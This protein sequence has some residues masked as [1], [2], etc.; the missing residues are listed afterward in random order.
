MT[1]LGE[2]N[3][4]TEPNA[5][6][7]KYSWLI[8]SDMPESTIHIHAT[9]KDSLGNSST[10]CMADRYIKVVADEEEKGQPYCGNGIIDPGET[11]DDGNIIN[12]DGCSST[13]QAEI[14][15]EDTAGGIWGFIILKIKKIFLTLFHL[16]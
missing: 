8:P 15:T 1:V 11:C 2:S 10:T 13:C 5:V 12:G 4:R 9:W 7:W 6:D 16:E 3:V 14:P